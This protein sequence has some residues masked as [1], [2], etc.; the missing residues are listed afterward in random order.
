MT[1]IWDKFDKAIDTKALQE[2]AK[3]AAE[4]KRGEYKEVPSGRYEVKITKLELGESKSEKPMLVCWMQILDGEYKGSYIFMNQVLH[5][6]FG[7]H[8]ANDFLRSLES[9]L[10]IRFETFKQYNDLLLEI[11]ETIDGSM[12]YAIEY[13]EDKKGYKTYKVVETFDAA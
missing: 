9:G 10:E 7:I 4:N 8:K 5:V 13:G 12:E 1:N 3:A 2:D 6:G 11:H